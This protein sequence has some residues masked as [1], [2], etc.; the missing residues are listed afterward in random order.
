MAFRAVADAEPIPGYRLLERLG[1]GGY[2]EVWKVSAPGGL[3]K[4]IKFIYGHLDDSRAGQEVKALNRI[5]GVR[6]PF[7]LAIERV[8]IIDGQ[9]AILTELADETLTARFEHFRKQGE[10][11]I[12]RPILLGYMRDVADGLDYMSDKYSLQHLD[13]KP[14][15]LLLVA[16]RLKVADFG[17]VKDLHGDDVTATGGVSPAYAACEFF[18][19]R[20][21]RY[22][23]QYSLAIVYMEMLTGCRPFPGTTAV[24]L[25]LQHSTGK[26]MLD[27]LPAEDRPAVARALSKDPNER[28]PSCKD[29]VAA[30]ESQSRR[31]SGD[32]PECPER[33]SSAIGIVDPETEV[34]GHPR[35]P[36]PLPED[37][38]TA[39][40]KTSAPALLGLASV[41]NERK[42]AHEIFPVRPTVFIGVG[43]MGSATI[44]H[45]RRRL[46][47]GFGNHSSLP[48]LRTLLIDT[49]RHELH[50]ATDRNDSGRVPPEDCVYIGLQK[51]ENYRSQS[52]EILRWMDRRWFYG[53]PKS[54]QTE[55]LRPLGRLALLDHADR[56]REV[57]TEAIAGVM[58]K[59][60]DSVGTVP[61]L[62]APPHVVIV[63]SLAGGTGSGSLIDIVH[64]VRSVMK[65]LRVPS[66]GLS[67]ILLHATSPKPAQKEIARANAYASL[68]EL[69]HLLHPNS[70]YP[71]EPALGL[72]ELPNQGEL[73]RDCYL[74]HLGEDLSQE[75]SQDSTDLV[76]EYLLLQTATGWR[77][78]IEDH[79]DHS[80][81]PAPLD[82]EESTIRSLGLYR[83]RFRRHDL[84]RRVT[85]I[86]CRHILSRWHGDL[87]AII[88]SEDE[89][90]EFSDANRSRWL[91]EVGEV[92]AAKLFAKLDLKD[93]SVLEHVELTTKTPID[94]NPATVCESILHQAVAKHAAGGSGAELAASVLREMDLH[95]GA[96]EL[97]SN[98]RQTVQS[99]Y[100][101]KIMERAR[102]GAEPNC[103]RILDWVRQ[104]VANPDWRI[105]PAMI[106]TDMLV[107][108]LITRI[109]TAQRQFQES[110][111]ERKHARDVLSGEMGASGRWLSRPVS[112]DEIVSMSRS[113][114]NA[115]LREIAREAIAESFRLLYRTTT[116]ARA[117]L[118]D[119]RQRCAGWADRLEKLGKET[120]RWNE[121]G[122]SVNGVDLLPGKASSLAEAAAI[123]A[124]RFASTSFFSDVEERIETELFSELGGIWNLATENISALEEAINHRLPEIVMNSVMASLEAVDS[125]S[126]FFE[127]QA[128]MTDALREIKRMLEKARPKLAV[129]GGKPRLLLGVPNS[130]PGRSF[131]ELVVAQLPNATSPVGILG[132]VLFC[133]EATGLPISRVA[134]EIIGN[135][136]AFVQVGSRLTTRIDMTLAPLHGAHA[137]VGRRG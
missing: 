41:D 129:A 64:L 16:D 71:G 98:P 115:R 91:K 106:A 70:N 13:V 100:E 120:E 126:L 43:G 75:E 60:R 109:E 2:G 119:L 23:D 117:R 5:R 105:K 76:A 80:R 133:Y 108:Q 111:R 121:S 28:F 45:L 47:E 124:R 87:G 35:K 32:E 81:G 136:V 78:F 4:A 67:A 127:K 24:Q 99:P 18:D 128:G 123:M 7:L 97:D 125:A 48:M 9:L 3:Y 116:E 33:V 36:G 15:N 122:S 19:G 12:P 86:C 134:E 17:L 118:L 113:Y 68:L 8:E 46:H 79:R 73:L 82:S 6:H 89:G 69:N 84:A 40:L 77:K 101:K 62:D 44:V 93:T 49:D 110:I 34:D 39:H 66:G 29:F 95:L 102:S 53:L 94:S 85:Q 114:F 38:A 135:E 90:S 57:I 61:R 59:T 20:V 131:R 10:V 30:I 56:V 63:L 137:P 92:E 132:D 11:G 42:D 14:G 130:P 1:S 72:D 37:E 58:E 31:K 50:M 107:S 52:R 51:P 27:P 103:R 96:G 54:Q 104:A 74:V 112:T 25:A 55:G 21:S 22:S 88:S 65:D 26:P 83:M